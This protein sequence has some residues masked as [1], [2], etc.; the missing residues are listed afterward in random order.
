MSVR[1]TVLTA[2]KNR[3]GEWISGEALSKSLKVSRTTVWKQIKSLIGEGYK[4]D[5]SP[6]KGYRISA[7]I[8]VLSPEEVCP[9]LETRVLGKTQYLY[10]RETDSTNNQAR[11]LASD[12]FPEG[13]VVVAE[14][15]TAGKGRRGREWYSPRNQGIYVSIILRPVL[16]L[17]EISRIPLMAAVATAEALQ[18]ELNLNPAIKW[19]ND[20]L[21]NN[22]KIVGIL[23][24]AV[25]DMDGVQY[26]VMGIGINI[27]NKL[28]DFPADLRTPATSVLIEQDRPI[29]RIRLLQQ[30]LLRLE[31]HYN[32]L[33]SGNF[34]LTLEKARS[35]S[36][37][38]GQKV[39]L[40]SGNEVVSGQALDINE[41]GYLLVRDENG[42]IHT[43]M[44][45]E[46]S[47]LPAVSSD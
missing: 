12:G 34:I 39:K 23:S 19:P 20:I 1:E 45:G 40:D 27:N 8:D 2:L 25:A 32:L 36:L 30:L 22:R 26:I 24:E 28:E 21:I 43:V 29:S 33:L 17:N 3:N 9:G 15:Q 18:H 4:I 10:F 47:V 6:K 35:L 37:V 13:T 14:T 42:T 44:S 16:P 7:P 38:F 5:S 46:I 31:Y 41:N 11:R